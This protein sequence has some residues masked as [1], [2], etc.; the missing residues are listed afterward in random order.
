MRIHLFGIHRVR[1]NRRDGRGLLSLT[2]V[3]AGA[4]GQNEAAL[5][6]VMSTESGGIRPRLRNRATSST[7]ARPHPESGL[8]ASSPNERHPCRT[9]FIHRVEERTDNC[10]FLVRAQRQQDHEWR[11]SRLGAHS[12]SVRSKIFFSVVMPAAQNPV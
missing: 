8:N 7:C 6:A 12:H 4:T 9:V 1:K 3:D 11:R 2:T 10:D 5:L